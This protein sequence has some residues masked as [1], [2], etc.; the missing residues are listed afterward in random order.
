[1]TGVSH[2]VHAE[3]VHRDRDG[4]I[5]SIENTEIPIQSQEEEKEWLRFFQQD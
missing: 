1:M 2:K 3:I 4:N 5:K